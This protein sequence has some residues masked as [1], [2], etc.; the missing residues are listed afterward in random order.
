[1]II[2]FCGI[3]LLF[4]KIMWRE[5]LEFLA[6][7][8]VAFC[9]FYSFPWLEPSCRKDVHMMY[10]VSFLIMDHR[11]PPYLIM[12]LNYNFCIVEKVGL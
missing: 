8:T 3:E 6:I 12:W 11:P 1:M 4:V 2:T 5:T 9:P 7:A 10:N